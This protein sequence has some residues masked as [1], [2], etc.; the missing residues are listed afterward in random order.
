MVLPKLKKNSVSTT[1]SSGIDNS[2]V[3]IPVSELS[4]FHDADGTLITDGI[5]IGFDDAD[6]T[7]AE[8]I[9][10]TGASATS[11]AG[12]LTGATR[13]VK[14][15]GTIGAAS[16]WVS[17]TAVAVMFST[18]IYEKIKDEKAD[19]ASPALT[20]APTAPTAAAGTDTTQIAT[21]AYVEEQRKNKNYI[22]NGN[23]DIWQRGT[24]FTNPTDVSY[25]ADRWRARSQFLTTTVSKT[26]T[27]TLE[28]DKPST[29]GWC[30]VQQQIESNKTLSGKTVTFSAKIKGV[31]GGF[32][33]GLS[34]DGVASQNASGMVWN[35]P[36][37]LASQI[38]D[39][40]S[41]FEVYSITAT[42]PVYNGLDYSIVVGVDI[43]DAYTGSTSDKI[44]IKEVQ[45]EDGSVATPFEY[46]PIS[47][48]LLLCQRYCQAI[49]TVALAE[50]VGIG[51]AASTTVAYIN[52]PL[53]TEMRSTPTLTAT[54]TDWQLDDTA[55]APT[56]VTALVIDDLTLSSKHDVV[57]RASAASGLA[58]YRPYYLVGDGTAGRKL[59]F[60]AEL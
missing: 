51:T 6:E 25:T 45:F 48:E 43:R 24:T 46:R 56:D 58:Q 59:I 23:F 8:E 60:S 14:A 28:F 47:E 49:T 27:G 31:S 5:V 40:T 10:V 15:D 35:T 26:A 7:A 22:I 57:L 13:G 54:A 4:V 53:I 37:N 30:N 21:C 38:F 52:V 42:I 29:Q 12:N 9:T 44:E 33:A 41:S 17:G 39:L 18:G 20:G 2:T 34:I 11:G 36:T 19:L 1:L 3:T 16:A 32:K 55:N 50:S